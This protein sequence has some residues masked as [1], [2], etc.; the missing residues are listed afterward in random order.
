MDDLF[1]GLPGADTVTHGKTSDG[2]TVQLKP[3][4]LEAKYDLS[5]Q[6]PNW[7]TEYN[8]GAMNGF[9]QEVVIPD[10]GYT[11]PPDAAYGYV[12]HGESAPYFQMAER[13]AFADRMFQTNQG[14][15]FPSH[16][17]IIS[18]TSQ[19]HTGS[20]LLVSENVTKYVSEHDG[21]C[22]ATPGAEVLLIDRS[23]NENQSIF[24][25][26]DHR[27]LMDMLDAHGV[28]W[29]Y[30]TP[31]TYYIWSAVDAIHHLRYG[32]DWVHVVTP[33]TTILNDISSG[34][35][36]SVSW[37]VPTNGNSDHAGS[38]SNTG[39]SWVASVV[40]AVG[41][42]QYWNSTAIFVTWDDWGGWY[43]HVAPQIYDSY[44]L[45]FRVPLIVISP[46]ARSGYVSHTQ[47]EFGSIL[48]FIEERYSL[49][50]LGYTD[51]RADDLSDC[52][53]FTQTPL[54]FKTIS[55]PLSG[56]Q[57]LARWRFGPPDND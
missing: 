3:I 19:P 27:T 24:P 48:K 47:H 10:P 33:E 12:P 54:Q 14:P 56:R 57:L 43:D 55:A 18:G 15:S 42:S 32:P 9:D 29:T 45:G 40:N 4:P 41:Q 35:L 44:E 37:V 8:G 30:Y 50:S 25:C 53:D 36:P 11:P 7:L 17:Y 20:P 5:H 13:Y 1:N 16:Q 52:F 2:R 39:P 46:Y 6:H 31:N 21:G 28:S 34:T 22:D 38:D 49:G 23:G 26:L 51:A